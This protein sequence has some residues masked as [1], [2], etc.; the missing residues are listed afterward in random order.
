MAPSYLDIGWGMI[1]FSDPLQRREIPKLPFASREAKGSGAKGWE[2]RSSRYGAV[3]HQAKHGPT[4]ASAI[5]LCSKTIGPS[6]FD[7]QMDQHRKKIYLNRRVTIFPSR[8]ALRPRLLT[9]VDKPLSIDQAVRAH[10]LVSNQKT[11]RVIRSNCNI[12]NASSAK[13]TSSPLS[14]A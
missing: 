4:S 7:N 5:P 10:L 8:W 11:D 14:T 2:H 9:N 13:V 6:R 1:S 3:L 12:S